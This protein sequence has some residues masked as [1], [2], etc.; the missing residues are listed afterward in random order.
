MAFDRRFHPNF[1]VLITFQNCNGQNAVIAHC[2]TA[3]VHRLATH[4]PLRP[5]TACSYYTVDLLLCLLQL[6]QTIPLFD[7]E[8]VVTLSH[9]ITPHRSIDSLP[10]GTLS[11]TATYRAPSPAHCLTPPCLAVTHRW[12]LSPISVMNDIELCL[13]SD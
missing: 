3:Y 4:V 7:S 5:S 12:A 8:I 6:S 13:I 2:L 9:Y 11:H 1:I 10:H